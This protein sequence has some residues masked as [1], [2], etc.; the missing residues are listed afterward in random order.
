ML[1]HVLLVAPR[2]AALSS[3]LQTYDRRLCKSQ[4]TQNC[5][6]DVALVFCKQG[7]CS[8]ASSGLLIEPS[9][10]GGLLQASPQRL[11]DML[12]MR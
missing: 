8:G 3:V 10:S 2:F 11:L 12:H 6:A 7:T 9:P 5:S 1:P 4:V